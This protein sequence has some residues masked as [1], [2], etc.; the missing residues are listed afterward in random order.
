M[1]LS[2]LA[3]CHIRTHTSTHH[4]TR[5]E[6]ITTLDYEW[7]VIQGRQ[8]YRWTIWV[9]SYG[10]CWGTP[11]SSLLA[12]EPQTDS[13]LW[14]IYSLARLS[15]LMAVIMYIIQIRVICQVCLVLCDCLPISKR[16]RPKGLD[17]HQFCGHTILP[18]TSMP[19]DLLILS[20][21]QI[22]AYV[23]FASSSLLMILRV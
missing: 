22:F 10:L 21:F 8:P 23:T 3:L 1:G 2:S 4:H 11:L 9:C 15:M 5:W 6:F 19:N 14:Q 13:S 12:S 17:H 18:F 20:F 7:R 16:L